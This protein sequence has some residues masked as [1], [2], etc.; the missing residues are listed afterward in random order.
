MK[1]L[2]LMIV[3]LFSAVGCMNNRWGLLYDGQ[4]SSS[5]RVQAY[6][7]KYGLTY[8][9][10]FNQLHTHEQQMWN[11]INERQHNE[12]GMHQPPV[13]ATEAKQVDPVL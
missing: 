8:E 12:Q 9:E 1:H 5:D 6:A 3:L 4:Y 10:A 11:E 13:N 7:D 2:L